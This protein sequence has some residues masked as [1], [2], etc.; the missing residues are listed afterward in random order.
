VS[1]H[2]F[3]VVGWDAN[4]KKGSRGEAQKMLDTVSKHNIKVMTNP[5]SGLK[6][7]P[8]AVELAHSGKMRGKPVIFIDEEAIKSQKSSGIIMI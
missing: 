8:K 1:S 5:F 4:E 7:L 2:H 3:L 6:E